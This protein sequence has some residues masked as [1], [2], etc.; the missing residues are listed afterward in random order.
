LTVEIFTIGHSTHPA[1][2]FLALLREHDIRQLA[3][4]RTIPKS[5][6]HPQFTGTTLDSFL[7]AHEIT[8]RHYPGLGGLR[9]PLTKS[10]NTAWRNASFRGYADYMQTEEFSRAADSLL[11]FASLGRTAV[12]CAEAVWWQ[13][14]RQL[15]ADAL[16]VRGVQVRHIIPGSET[17]PHRLSE[18]AQVDDRRV[19]YPG[20]L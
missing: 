2:R 16:L 12:M 7:A 1:E 4:I 11:E 19:T 15:L 20:L 8:Y 13:C 17:K 6:R 14:H 10:V 3:D 9:K 5:R 18:F